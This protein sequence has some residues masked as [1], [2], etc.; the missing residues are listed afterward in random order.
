MKQSLLPPSNPSKPPNNP[1]AIFCA[2]HIS[3]EQQII[4][5]GAVI[6]YAGDIVKEV[7]P[8][9]FYYYGVVVHG[10]GLMCVAVGLKIVQKV[11]RVKLLQYGGVAICC[12]LL[13]TGINFLRDK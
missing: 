3:F 6:V 8:E 4:G 7:V 2:L 1:L 5:I 11:G 9:L 13:V 12:C 10:F